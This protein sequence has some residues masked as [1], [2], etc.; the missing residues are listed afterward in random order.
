MFGS[1][2][3]N[4]FLNLFWN[5]NEIETTIGMILH[6]K[7]YFWLHAYCKQAENKLTNSE[8]FN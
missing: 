8:N 5:I 1:I 7:I 4:Y 2:N 6:M 3:K